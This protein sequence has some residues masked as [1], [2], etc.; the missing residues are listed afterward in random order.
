MPYSKYFKPGQKLLL[1]ALAA[2][3]EQERFD[4]LTGYLRSQDAEHLELDL[5]YR[6]KDGEGYPFQPGMAFELLGEALGLGVRLTGSFES[7]RN[8][9]QVRIRH[10]G[11]LQLIRR[12]TFRRRD[13]TIG[14]RYTRGRGELLTFRT[15]WEKNTRILN[16]AN[17]LGKLPPFPRCRVNLS[18]GGMRLALKG[19]VETADLLLLILEI[20]DGK[21]PVCTLGEVVWVGDESPEGRR[22]AGVQFINILEADR[23]RLDQFVVSGEVEEEDAPQRANA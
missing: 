21:A 7:E 9:E 20:P 12:R 19:P 2:G 23:R 11:D 18:G 8:S 16:Q 13:A 1:R 15:Q 14:L 10:N 22:Q 6:V 4:A 3:S 5:P 17:G